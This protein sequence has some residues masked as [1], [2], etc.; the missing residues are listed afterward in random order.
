MNIS[1]FTDLCRSLE[2]WPRNFQQYYDIWSIRKKSGGRRWIYAPKGELREAQEVL[3][4][5][6]L[7][8]EYHP[9]ACAYLPGCSPKK[10]FERHLDNLKNGG[11]LLT[12]DIKDFFGHITGEMLTE[13]GMTQ[14]EMLV[15]CIPHP[16]RTWV[17]AQGG[18]TSP[19]AANLAA[20]E[21][22]IV[23]D[24]WS[25][26]YG[27]M[28]TRYADDL[29]FS[30]VGDFRELKPVVSINRILGDHGFRI[31]SGKVKMQPPGSGQAYLGLIY[32]VDGNLSISHRYRNRA[33]AMHHN[34]QIGR[35]TNKHVVQGV[36]NYVKS[37]NPVQ[38]CKLIGE[39]VCQRT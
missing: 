35:T 7:Q 24:D 1:I 22:D 28:Y 4:F 16:Q 6:L 14:E 15:C 20:S 29:G 8:K 18:V 13:H 17:L 30:K 31:A 36:L 38:H 26:K 5:H 12:L 19:L 34:Q 27:L 9:A 23:L 10:A 39:K 21:L 33:R 32:T 25:Q 37:V 2:D 11:W 3:N